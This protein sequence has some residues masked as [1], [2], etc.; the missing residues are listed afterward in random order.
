M[1]VISTI[2]FFFFIPG[3]ILCQALN[4]PSITPRLR[5]QY[6]IVLRKLCSKCKILPVSHILDQE[7]TKTNELPYAN[8][9]FA[10]VYRGLYKGNQVAIKSLRISSQDDPEKVKM[11]KIAAIIRRYFADST[12]F[13]AC[14]SATVKRQLPGSN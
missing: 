8:G 5:R 11:V 2:F 10:D 3:P 14:F 13:V 1:V 9:G 4:S 12:Y 6:M 7:L